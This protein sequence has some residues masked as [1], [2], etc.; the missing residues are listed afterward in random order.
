MKIKINTKQIGKKKN[1]VQTIDF[2]LE[3][4]PKTVGELL[5]ETVKTCVKEYKQRQES[6]E[7]L[8]VLSSTEIID[9]A[10]AGKVSFGNNNGE[11]TPSL[12]EAQETARQAFLDG[13]VVVFIEEKEQDLLET[14]ISLNEDTTITFVKMA[15]LSGRMW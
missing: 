13:I 10:T 9:K 2:C 8:Q 7:V 5:D 4:T 3:N 11:H 1:A 15:M 14:P 12:N 6:G